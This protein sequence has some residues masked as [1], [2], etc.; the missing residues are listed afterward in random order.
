MNKTL[1]LFSR[2]IEYNK[3]KKA[4]EKNVTCDM[5]ET[6]EDDPR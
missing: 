3:A 4:T 6:E 5:K 2:T 1:L